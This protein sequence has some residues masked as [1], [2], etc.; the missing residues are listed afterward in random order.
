MEAKLMYLLV[1]YGY[2][3]L[4]GVLMLGIVGVPIPDE[5]V[6]TYA[7]YSI[8]KGELHYIPTALVSVAGSFTGMSISYW[9]GYW[10]GYPLLIKYG[11]YVHITPGRLQRSEQ[12]FRRFGKFAVTIG[13]FVP[14]LRHLTALFAGVS[15]WPYGTFALFALPGAVIWAVTF[16]TIGVLIGEH[17]KRVIFEIHRYSVL[18][19]IAAAGLLVIVWLLSRWR[20]RKGGR[21][22]EN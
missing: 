4:F 8:Y 9:A 16:I 1:H 18:T 15:R 20:S 5:V 10:M 17:W 19:V 2:F 7:G 13:Y 11:K 22:N 14:G 21:T 3:G 6:M 12:W